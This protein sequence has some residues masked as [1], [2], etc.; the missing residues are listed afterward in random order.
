MQTF[1][2]ASLSGNRNFHNLLNS[3]ATFQNPKRS[4]KL[5]NKKYFRNAQMIENIAK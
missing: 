1:V 4:A 2:Q 3:N 5:R